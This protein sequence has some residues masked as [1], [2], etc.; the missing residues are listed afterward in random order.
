MADGRA[1]YVVTLTVEERDHLKAMLSGGRHAARRINHAH[2]LLLA[3]RGPDGPGLF[4]KQIVAALNT[5]MNTVARVRQTFVE[6]GFDAALDPRPSRRKY[7][8]KIDGILE[9]KLTMLACSDPPDDRE[10]WTMQLLADKMVTLNWIDSVSRCTVQRTLKKNELRPWLNESW[11]IADHQD[12]AFVAAMED[13]LDVYQ[14]HIDPSRPVICMDEMPKQ[15]IGE[16]RTPIPAKPGQLRRYDYEYV[17]NGTTNVFMFFAPLLGWRRATVRERKTRID[18]AQ[19][20]KRLIDEDFP[21]A[22]KIVLVM[23]NLKTHGIASLYAAYAPDEA[24]R[25]AQ[26]L[27]LHYTPKH[28]SWLNMAE[29]ELS[30]LSRQATHGRIPAADQLIARIEAWQDNRNKAHAKTNWR[31]TTE[32]A[33]IKL[34]KLYPSIHLR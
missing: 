23:D 3:D 1:V 9:A 30:V 4:D 11:C 6:E 14:R 18:W 22:E 12:P 32:D 26:K 25:L 10:S 31:F 28:G 5:S 20:V 33:R 24:H 17:R 13:V 21:D 16:S 34:T 27:E 15:L 19:E 29:I 8:H 7:H 2:I